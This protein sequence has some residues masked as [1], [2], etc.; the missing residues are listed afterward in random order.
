MNNLKNL[1]D[2]NL[3]FGPQHPSAHGVL[4]LIL[5][6]SG[7]KI[8]WADPHIGL[9]HRG[10]EKL[11]EH[12]TYLQALPYM[13]RLDY[14]SVLAQEHAYVLA[15][16]KLISCN[17]LP[18]F[19]KARVLFAE[20][21]RVLNHLLAITTHALD[22]GALTPFLW[23]FEEREQLMSFYERISGARMHAAYFRVG[24][25]AR[26]LDKKLLSDILVFSDRF[27]NKLSELE[28]L[29]T[30]NPIWIQRL[31]GIGT[32]GKDEALA[33]GF[34]GVMLRSTGV[35]WDLRK[36]N[37][38]DSYDFYRFNVPVGSQGDCY[39]RYL[40]RIAEMYE[41]LKLISQAARDLWKDAESA[42]WTRDFDGVKKNDS[43]LI[44]SR[45]S[46]MRTSMES[47]IQHYKQHSD[48]YGVPTGS[49]Y[50]A[51]EAPK[52]EFG[53]A[54]VSNGS[55]KP[56]RCKIKSPGFLHLQALNALSKGHFLADVVAIIGTLDI[57]FGE[58]DR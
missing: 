27:C 57:V 10:T 49:A 22:V 20:I 44:T 19:Q 40:L 21:T 29:L 3:N 33:R 16:E 36:S 56:Y 45:R 32:I 42:S 11:I 30:T 17:V 34:S 31:R 51:V 39:D 46:E 41:S 5:S 38:Y 58:V 2:F 37:P 24:G 48:P 53:I 18:M 9:L 54:L 28:S 55:N 52:G 1:H 25:V 35:N 43:E 47:L 50:S 26:R 8:K 13:D 6:L 14:V 12:K 23:A 15:V 4:R 7:E